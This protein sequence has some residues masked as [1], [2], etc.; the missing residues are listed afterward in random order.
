MSGFDSSTICGTQNIG[1]F[2]HEVGHYLGL[3]HT[4]ANVFDTVAQAEVWLKDHKG[5]VSSFDGDGLSETPPDPFIGAIQ[6]DRASSVVLLGN[7]VVFPRTN[8]MSYWYFRPKTLSPRQ[9]EIARWFAQRRLRSG[10]PTNLAWR[11]PLEVETLEITEKAAFALTCSA[12]SSLAQPIGAVIRN[13]G[14]EGGRGTLWLLPC[15]WRSLDV[16]N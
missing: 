15:L 9:V 3:L 14:S 5:E 16:I 8:I 2:A 7:K 11:T 13:F 1:I 6:C 12:W 4:H 10:M